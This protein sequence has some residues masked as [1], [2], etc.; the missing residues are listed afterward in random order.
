MGAK[1]GKD[2]KSVKGLDGEEPKSGQNKGKICPLL[3]TP[4]NTATFGMV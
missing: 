3:K 1:N 4:A 2:S